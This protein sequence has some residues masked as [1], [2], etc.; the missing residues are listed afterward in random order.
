MK[1]ELR[2]EWK[3]KEIGIFGSYIRGKQKKQSDIDLSVKE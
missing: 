1:E 2:R 3:V